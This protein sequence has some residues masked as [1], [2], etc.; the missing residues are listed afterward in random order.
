[1]DLKLTF[2]AAA[3]ACALCSAPT[4]F[5]APVTNDEYK[6]AKNRIGAEYKDAKATCDKLS[7]NAKDICIQEAKG[8]EKVARAELE[9]NRSGKPGD[10]SKL[11][12]VRADAAYAVAKEKCDDRSGND[13]DVC[14]KQAKTDHTKALADAK[15]N[16]KV[17]AARKDASED[18]RDAEY[19]LAKEKCDALAGDAKS[20]CLATAKSRFG[21]T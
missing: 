5:A 7:D 10:A 16:S 6:A 18:K 9:Y 11:A 21:K 1:M 4:L 20:S 8:H 3:F 12:T 13:K 2:R 15:A 19:N 17:A 14:V